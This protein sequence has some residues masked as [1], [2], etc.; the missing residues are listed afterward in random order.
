MNAIDAINNLDYQVYKSLWEEFWIK[1]LGY[2]PADR[3][4]A[5]RIISFKQARSEDE[6]IGREFVKFCKNKVNK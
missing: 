6:E 3:K 2:N 1:K 4:M 5:I